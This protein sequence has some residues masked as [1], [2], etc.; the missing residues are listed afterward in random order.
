MAIC[1]TLTPFESA[2]LRSASTSARLRSTFSPWKRGLCARK[3]FSP[4]LSF[5][6]CPLMR[7]RDSTP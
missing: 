1:A 4:A 6:Q 5:V 3:S 7:P 2:I